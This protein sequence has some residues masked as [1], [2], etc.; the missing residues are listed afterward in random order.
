MPISGNARIT[1]G[2]SALLVAS[3]DVDGSSAVDTA[4]C[5]SVARASTDSKMASAAAA[6]ASAATSRCTSSDGGTGGGA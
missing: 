1:A 5:A 4:A 2:D 6:C 3:V